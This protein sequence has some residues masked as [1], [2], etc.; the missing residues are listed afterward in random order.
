MDTDEGQRTTARLLQETQCVLGATVEPTYATIDEPMTAATGGSAAVISDI[1]AT[2]DPRKLTSS[3]VGERRP[4]PSEMRARLPAGSFSP[5][6]FDKE[7]QSRH[8]VRP[9]DAD[10]PWHSHHSSRESSVITSLPD[11]ETKPQISEASSPA[12]PTRSMEIIRTPGVAGEQEYTERGSYA[13]SVLTLDTRLLQ[14]I[15]SGRWTRQCSTIWIHSEL[16]LV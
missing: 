5:F 16:V 9:E 13:E 15:N 4:A 10:K 2:Q 7:F 1:L 14:D 12:S 6:D 3:E 8:G 11:Q